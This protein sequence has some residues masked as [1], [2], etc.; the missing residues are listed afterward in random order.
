M[1]RGSVK[2]RIASKGDFFSHKKGAII[3]G[4]R[5][6]QILLT[7]NCAKYFVLLSH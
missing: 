1:E 2:C 5:L 4:R 6:F 7:G 3:L